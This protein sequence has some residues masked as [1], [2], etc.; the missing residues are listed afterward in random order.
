L[1]RVYQDEGCAFVC[2]TDHAE[3]FDSARLDQYRNECQALSDDQFLFVAGLEYRCEREMHILGYGATK[4]V[5]SEDPETVIRGIEE[6][7][8]ISVIAHP[9]NDFFDW[10]RK[11]QTLPR[12]IETWNSKYDGR[13]A[14]RPGTFAL[15]QDLRQRKPELLAFYGQ[16]LHWKKQFRGLFVELDAAS[17]SAPGILQALSQGAF[18]GIKGELTLASSGVVEQELLERFGKAQAASH[19]MW[20]FLKQSKQAMDR[21]GIRVP[22]RLKAQLRRIF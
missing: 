19:R 15:Q 1:R 13:Y 4:S 14:P 12:G 7:G 6:Q 10:I 3:Y 22:E 17:L 5:S 18:R 16:D 9:K 11:F 20:R 8:A 21:A 2:M